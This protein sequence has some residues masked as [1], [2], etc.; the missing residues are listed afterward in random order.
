MTTERL[1]SA[2]HRRRRFAQEYSVH[3]N[4]AKAA[5]DAGYSA[6]TAKQTANRLL[7]RPDVQAMIRELDADKRERLGWDAE[8]VVTELERIYQRCMNGAPKFSRDTA[9]YHPETG[10]L[11]IEWHPTPAIRALETIAKVAGLFDVVEEEI[12]TVFTLV[13]VRDLEDESDAEDVA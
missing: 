12:A 5:T 11:V 2:E 10:E 6:A 4:G 9:L 8:R 7:K 3:H 13:P 1:A